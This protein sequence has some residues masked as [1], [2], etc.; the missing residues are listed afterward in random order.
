M[1]LVQ[2]LLVESADGQEAEI[3]IAQLEEGLTLPHL[4]GLMGAVADKGSFQFPGLPTSISRHFGSN[5][6]GPLNGLFDSILLGPAQTK[7]RPANP[8]AE[9]LS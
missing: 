7:V 9:E 3:Y 4:S 6:Q 2:R 5:G 8:A 1:Q